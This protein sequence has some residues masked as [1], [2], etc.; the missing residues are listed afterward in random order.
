MKFPGETIEERFVAILSIGCV[1]VALTAIWP[2]HGVIWALSNGA[3]DSIRAILSHASTAGWVQAMGSVIGIGAAFLVS[4]LQLKKTQ[5][6]ERQRQ[7][8]ADLAVVRAAAGHVTTAH[9]LLQNVWKDRKVWKDEQ[10]ARDAYIWRLENSISVFDLLLAKNLPGLALKFIVD[11]RGAVA[12]ATASMKPPG[13]NA[14]HIQ[15]INF[16]MQDVERCSNV[17]NLYAIH[18]ERGSSEEYNVLHG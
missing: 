16:A 17:L 2:G 8:D 18:I 12:V 7:T 5:A 13:Y 4:H 10:Y 6:H 11:A 1:F 9:R 3:I 14:V 15:A